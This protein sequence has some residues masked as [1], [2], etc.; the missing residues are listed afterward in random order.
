[1]RDELVDLELALQVVVHETRQLRAALDATESRALPD[2]ARDELECY[3]GVSAVEL[4]AWDA[5]VLRKWGGGQ[6]GRKHTSGGDL[7]ARR[8]NTDNDALAPALVARL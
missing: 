8:G 1:M 6:G 4:I 2:A 5:N 3:G 7:L